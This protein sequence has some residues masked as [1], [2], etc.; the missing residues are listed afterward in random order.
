MSRIAFLFP[1]QGAQS[2]GMGKRLA[3]STPAARRLYER[4][5]EILGYDLAKL[6]FEGPAPRGR[7]FPK[8]EAVSGTAWLAGRRFASFRGAGNP[9]QARE[10][11]PSGKRVAA[12]RFRKR[13]GPEGRAGRSS[14]QRFRRYPLAVEGAAMC[15]IRLRMAMELLGGITQG[16][17]ARA[18]GVSTAR[19]RTS[20]IP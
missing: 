20:E 8:R 18:S 16:E 9:L 4:A 14:T 2:V 13:P 15:P 7:A 19:M 1:G 6:C 5:G 17:L 12:S 3:E 10:T 11:T